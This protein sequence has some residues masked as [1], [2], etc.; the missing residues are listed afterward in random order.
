[1]PGVFP[2]YELNFRAAQNQSYIPSEQWKGI[3]QFLI[4]S[5]NLKLVQAA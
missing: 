3:V 4:S 1:M 5:S 2:A